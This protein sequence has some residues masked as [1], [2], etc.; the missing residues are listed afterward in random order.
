M[1][2]ARTYVIQVTSVTGHTL[3]A[4][5]EI[6][7]SADRCRLSASAVAGPRASGVT[8]RDPPSG[9]STDAVSRWDRRTTHRG[10]HTSAG[11]TDD[12]GSSFGAPAAGS[13]AVGVGRDPRV[14]GVPDRSP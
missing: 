8:A 12:P 11:T 14:D 3:D 6:G 1:W 9:G 4:H 5:R 10:G 7:S 13:A 2:I